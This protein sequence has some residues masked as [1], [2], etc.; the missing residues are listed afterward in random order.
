M[1]TA[2]KRDSKQADPFALATDNSMQWARSNRR[3][4][5]LTGGIAL[6][7]LIAIV[8]GYSIYEHRTTEAQTAFGA[9]M[10]TYQTPLVRPEQPLPPGMKAFN[11]AKER[12]A[13]A[14]TQFVNVAQR[15][16]LTEPGKLA[17]YFAG[18]TYMEEGQNS[19]AEDTLKKVAGSW[20][21]D[22]A[23]LGKLALA[24]LDQQTGRTDQAVEIYQQLAK[25]HATTVPPGLAQLQLAALYTAEGKTEDARHIYAELKDHDKDAKGKLG[26]AAQVASEKLNPQ[27]AA[28]GRP[29]R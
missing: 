6:A 22:T 14:N 15:F 27:A 7:L 16:G 26:V 28:P 13:K 23:A 9:A 10:Q 21:G 19:S 11:T 25:G 5:L 8:I 24:Q 3:A 12:A 20:N 17:Q 4:T 2:I 1:N 18:L 29:A